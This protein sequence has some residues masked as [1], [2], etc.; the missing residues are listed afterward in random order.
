MICSNLSYQS[1]CWGTFSVST[2]HYDA[3]LQRYHWHNK[4]FTPMYIT[5]F[6][7]LSFEVLCRN[8]IYSW[9]NTTTIL[10]VYSCY[11]SVSKNITCLVVLKL[12]HKFENLMKMINK[13]KN[14]GLLIWRSSLIT[15]KEDQNILI[16]MC[17]SV[18]FLRYWPF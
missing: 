8:V 15:Q 3:A 2:F 16:K 4:M 1:I 6:I 14:W 13:Q 9:I 5:L 7:G 17:N 10:H 18:T 11:N 12:M